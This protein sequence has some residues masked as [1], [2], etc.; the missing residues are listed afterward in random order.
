MLLLFNYEKLLEDAFL[1]YFKMKKFLK[2]CKKNDEVS[3]LAKRH[4]SF[5]IFDLEMLLIGVLSQFFVVICFSTSLL[6]II[7]II[8]SVMVIIIIVTFFLFCSVS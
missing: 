6:R 4:Y 8:I 7:V 1:K 3:T 5:S 2:I